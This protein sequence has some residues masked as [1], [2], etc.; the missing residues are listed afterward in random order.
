ERAML[1]RLRQDLNIESSTELFP[2]TYNIEVH[3][4]QAAF[5]LMSSRFEGLPLV[6]IEAQ[7]YGLPV[8]SFDCD[9]GPA[10][11]IQNSGWIV[12]PNSI[13]AFSNSCKEAINV[14]YTP[15]YQDLVTASK[16]VNKTFC[17]DVIVDSWLR[18]L[19]D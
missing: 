6:L 7:A 17:L 1:E 9:T 19:S 12:E 18:L 11:I 8:V 14:F 4:Q 13:H 3:Y 2:R 10:E 16:N 5:F 15:E